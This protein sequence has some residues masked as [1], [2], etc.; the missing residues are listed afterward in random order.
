MNDDAAKDVIRVLAAQ[1]VL[2]NSNLEKAN[3]AA[4]KAERAISDAEALLGKLGKPLPERSRSELTPFP[5]EPPRLR[6]WAE[7]VDEA[8]A[9]SF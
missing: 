3:T 6:S 4:S 5:A 2:L 1:G 7:I 9:R 8:R